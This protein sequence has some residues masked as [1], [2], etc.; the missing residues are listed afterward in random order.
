[1]TSSKENKRLTNTVQLSK[2]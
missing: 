1:M 2:E